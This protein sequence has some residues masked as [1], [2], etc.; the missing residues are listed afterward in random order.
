MTSSLGNLQLD[1]ETKKVDGSHRR[2]KSH[3]DLGVARGAQFYDTSMKSDFKAVSAPYNKAPGITTNSSI[4]L[5]YYSGEPVTMPT[6][7]SDFPSHAG[8]PKLIPNP[9]AVDNLKKSHIKPP[10]PE[11]REFSTTHQRTYTPKKTKRRC[12]DAGGLQRS[13]VPLGTL[14]TY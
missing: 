12:V 9:L 13:S 8:V 14:N 7:W 2:T 5:D 11:E 1:I 6:S 10:I 3:V 4:P